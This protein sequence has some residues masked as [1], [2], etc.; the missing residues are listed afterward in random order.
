VSS[1]AVV[2]SRSVG[3]IVAGKGGI[4]LNCRFTNRKAIGLPLEGFG[5][6]IRDWPRIPDFWRLGRVLA[7]GLPLSARDHVLGT[8]RSEVGRQLRVGDAQAVTATPTDQ[9]V[10]VAAS[11][12]Q[13][14]L[15]AM[16]TIDLPR[17]PG[18]SS[19]SRIRAR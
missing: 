16:R 9:W 3:D 11:C 4:E 15:G 17:T 6:L 2:A 8:G 7:A 10:E 13:S 12:L 5:E 19:F 14:K 1:D 18:K